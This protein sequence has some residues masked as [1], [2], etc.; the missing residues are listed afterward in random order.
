M[1]SVL[2]MLNQLGRYGATLGLAVAIVFHVS[3][4]F[5]LDLPP[6]VTT[7]LRLGLVPLAAIAVR[8]GLIQKWRDITIP[9]TKKKLASVP[10][11]EQWNRA[12]LCGFQRACETSRARRVDTIR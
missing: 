9:Q 3:G 4:Y 8:Q 2:K 11:L 7:A 10:L 6:P 12:C 1:T 5:W